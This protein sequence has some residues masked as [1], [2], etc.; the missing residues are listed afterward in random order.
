MC[1]SV[2]YV[3]LCLCVCLSL[4]VYASVSVYA[5]LSVCVVCVSEFLSVC[6]YVSIFLCMYEI[7]NMFLWSRFTSS[8]PET[9][10]TRFSKN[11]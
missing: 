4:S 1:V 2:I 8:V 3:H 11:L 7:K 5:S 10:C 6:D 9:L